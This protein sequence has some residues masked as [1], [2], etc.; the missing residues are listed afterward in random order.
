ML[1]TINIFRF[2]VP[3]SRVEWQCADSV[4]GSSSLTDGLTD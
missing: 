4:R 1:H 2:L 3:P